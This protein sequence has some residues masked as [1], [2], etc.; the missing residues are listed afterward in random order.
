MSVTTRRNWRVG[1]AAFVMAALVTGAPHAANAVW[2]AQASAA[3][4]VTRATTG[5]T[6]TAPGLPL[7][8]SLSG[9]GPTYTGTAD[10]AFTV[11]TAAGS[12]APSAASATIAPTALAGAGGGLPMTVE[13]AERSTTT[14]CSGTSGYAQV[15]PWTVANLPRPDGGASALFCVRVTITG[16]A[17]AV[18]GDYASVLLLAPLAVWGPNTTAGAGGWRVSPP[19]AVSILLVNGVPAPPPPVQLICTQVGGNVLM[20]DL[21]SG[22]I[23]TPFTLRLG[24][25]A[26]QLVYDSSWDYALGETLEGGVILYAEDLSGRGIASGTYSLSAVEQS[27]AVRGILSVRYT[28]S[29]ETLTCA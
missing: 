1:I 2:S 11:A 9:N 27:G 23:R 28:P 24:S 20:W 5:Y 6:V 4:P 18:N 12:P 26:G 13:I 22:S 21:P 14:G 17:S 3:V 8:F 7:T 10:I 15:M 29:P 19:S 16:L 25:A